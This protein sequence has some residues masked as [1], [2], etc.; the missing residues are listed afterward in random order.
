MAS[1]LD[2]YADLIIML[3]MS[4]L[5]F[6]SIFI[7]PASPLRITLSLLLLLFNPGFALTTALFPD[8]DSLSRLERLGLSIGISTALLPLIG[9]ILNY[10]PWGIRVE[11][12][13]IS[14]TLLVVL[15]SS[16]ALYRRNRVSREKHSVARFK[17]DLLRTPNTKWLDKFLFVS[18]VLFAVTTFGIL[19]YAVV[20]PQSERKFTEFY[21]LGPG[22]EAE[23][24]PQ[25]VTTGEPIALLIGAVNHEHTD[26]Q[27]HVEIERDNS[28]EQI[29]NLRLGYEDTWE[30]P[31]TFTLSEPGENRKVRFLL[32]KEGDSTPYRSLHLWITV[33]E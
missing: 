18:L 19:L 33:R 28:I 9:L 32:Y 30:Q 22:G 23:K 12:I 20:E 5:I 15:C 2:K 21:I 24:Y 7:I 29:A 31:Y 13:L 27:Y 16:V 3:A 11:T 26:V 10:S 14:V 8:R 4:S 17:P 25:E 6:V 1:K